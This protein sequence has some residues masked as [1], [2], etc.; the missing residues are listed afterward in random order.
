M[1][2]ERRVYA[3]D[4]WR[5]ETL[6]PPDEHADLHQ[7]KCGMTFVAKSSRCSFIRFTGKPGG[8]VHV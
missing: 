1:C 7:R 3:V 8:I 6:I 2:S 5:H 4:C